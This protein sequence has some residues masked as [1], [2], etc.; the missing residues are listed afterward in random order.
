MDK[1]FLALIAGVL[2]GL[3][4]ILGL[5]V[6]DHYRV[7]TIVHEEIITT[8]AVHPGEYIK[9]RIV[10]ERLRN[11]CTIHIEKIIHDGE[12]ARMDGQDEHFEAQPGPLGLNKPFLEKVLVPH[13]AAPGEGFYR[14]IR[15]YWCNPLEKYLRWARVIR[16]DDHP[17]R[18]VPR[19]RNLPSGSGFFA[20]S[21]RQSGARGP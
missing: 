16:T 1:F 18:I 8:P 11:D 20:P 12:N 14:A 4:G 15:S 19:G 21:V 7:P 9:V 3:A 6:R 5:M 10:A 13:H 2:I 17:F